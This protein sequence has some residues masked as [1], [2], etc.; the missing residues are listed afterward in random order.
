MTIERPRYVYAKPNGRLFFK[1]PKSGKLPLPALDADDFTASYHALMASVANNTLSLPIKSTHEKHLGF[2][3]EASVGGLAKAYFAS[4]PFD[5]LDTT[6]KQCR[7]LYIERCLQTPHPEVM[8]DGRLAPFAMWHLDELSKDTSRTLRGALVHERTR[9]RPLKKG[10]DLDNWR[11]VHMD[12]MRAMFRWAVDKPYRWSE[13]DPAHPSRTLRRRLTA[14][15]FT[16]L[17]A[18]DRSKGQHRAWD[19]SDFETL[20]AYFKLERLWGYRLGLAIMRYAFVRRSDAVRLGPQHVKDLA[21]RTANAPQLHLVFKEW[22]GSRSKTERRQNKERRVPILPQLQAIIDST[23]GAMQRDRFV[24]GRSDKPLTSNH[25]GTWL[26]DHAQRAGLP[27]ASTC[28]GVRHFAANTMAQNG[29][30][31]HLIAEWGGWKDI[32]NVVRYTKQVDKQKLMAAGAQ[33]VE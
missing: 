29:A 31:A 3:G 22:K 13:P 17:G 9:G 21:P 15:P 6:T 24:V 25:F 26:S 10:G 23:P 11:D 12:A 33:F 4:E 18:L 16:Q 30:S 2:S 8:A 20:M 32:R 28:H 7:R 27:P 5:R 19:Q 14:N 1:H